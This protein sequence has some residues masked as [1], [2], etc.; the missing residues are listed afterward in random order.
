MELVL[1]IDKVK[2]RHRGGILA[3]G[4][5]DGVHLGHQKVIKSLERRAKRLKKKRKRKR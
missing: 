3:L 5:F 1:G 4:T 2:K